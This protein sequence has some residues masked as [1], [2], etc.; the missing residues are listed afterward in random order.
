MAHWIR[1]VTLT[2]R[3]VEYLRNNPQKF[4]A[5][6]NQVIVENDGK[7]LGAFVTLGPFGCALH[8]GGA[9][10]EHHAAYR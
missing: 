7:L 1:L 4:L 5:D 6:M 10:R 3:G 9:F 2:E 8:C